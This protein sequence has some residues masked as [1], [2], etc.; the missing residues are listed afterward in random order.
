MFE[1][2]AER[3]FQF[4]S[5]LP[6]LPVPSLQDTLNKYL[7]AGESSFNTC[8]LI[9]WILDVITWAQD[10]YQTFSFH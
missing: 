2:T 1:S 4:Q 9:C 7:D 3:T 10:G 8:I 5:S 6:P